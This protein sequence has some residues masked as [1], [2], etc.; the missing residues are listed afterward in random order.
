MDCASQRRDQQ[1]PE[2]QTGVPIEC[3]P[4]ATLQLNSVDP[5]ARISASLLK[6]QWMCKRSHN[7]S[8]SWLCSGTLRQQCHQKG[9]VQRRPSSN[10]VRRN[11]RNVDQGL[12]SQ[13]EYQWYAY[14]AERTRLHLCSRR[15]E[16]SEC[17]DVMSEVSIEPQNADIVIAVAMFT[18]YVFALL[19]SAA[20]I[21][22]QSTVR[23]GSKPMSP[24]K[25]R[26]RDPFDYP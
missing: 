2:V 1:A 15:V 14:H 3:E 5:K 7:S 20:S 10:I 12:R 13:A 25:G 4:D 18:P 16:V 9:L 26:S 11:V 19:G 6:A 8:L 23:A 24:P 17:L 21:L 22:V